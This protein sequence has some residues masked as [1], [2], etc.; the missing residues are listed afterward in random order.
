MNMK[1]IFLFLSSI[2]IANISSATEWHVL[3]A[4]SMAMGGAGVALAGGP[5]G[6]YWNPAGLGQIDNP[7]GLQIPVGVHLAVSGS[8]LQGANDL[9]QIQKAC[10]SGSSD[11][12]QANINN[13]V[14]TMNQPG[15]GVRGDAGVGLDLK[16]K[17]VTVF[18]NS[19]AYIGGK[20]VV[21]TVNIIQAGSFNN[22]QSKI[23][24]RGILTTEIGVGYGRELDSLPG[25]LVGGNLK[26][27]VGKVGY[28][29]YLVLNNES[30]NSGSLNQFTK[31]AKQSIQPGVDLGI[32]WDINRSFGGA[33]MRPR[34]GLTARNI[35]NPKF[36]QPD[37]AKLA[38]EASKFSLQG[39]VRVGLAIS[40]L[41]FWNIVADADLT[42]NLT[43]LD[44]IASRMLGAGTEINVFN[45]SWINIPLRVGL[46]KN[47]AQPGSKTALTAGGGLNFLH[48]NV[49]AAV[50]AT[51]SNQTIQS[52]NKTKKIPSEIGASVQL[53][54]LFGG[55]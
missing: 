48:F 29:D 44:G 22:N 15:N 10:N 38:G 12:T 4:R 31:G 33:P 36:N 47:I 20:P 14:N 28:Y 30:G 1:K 50:T 23:T 7:S 5:V 26:G 9:Y 16:I 37:Q 13:A 45:R 54:L 11:C 19:L 24:L 32:L 18:V 43:P 46:E 42:R 52:Q 2:L 8:V 17:K 27:I 40:P 6:A 39:N 34:L 25:L 41:H 35:N 49:D 51:P 55:Q 21:D 3:G 53:G